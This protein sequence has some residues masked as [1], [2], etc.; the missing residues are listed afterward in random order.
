MSVTVESDNL[1]VLRPPSNSFVSVAPGDVLGYH[2]VH[3]SSA[4]G[5]ILLDPSFEDEVV[6]YGPPKAFAVSRTRDCPYMVGRDGDF[7]Q[8]TTA[9]PVISVIICK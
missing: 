8:V 3:S 7:R 6:W 2:I 4:G 5:G 9:A 1:I